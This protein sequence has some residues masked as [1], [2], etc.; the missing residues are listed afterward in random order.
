MMLENI[1][2]A[3]YF[4]E[5]DYPFIY[6]V[7]EEHEVDEDIKKII[8]EEKMSDELDEVLY[9]ISKEKGKVLYGIDGSHSELGFIHY[10]HSTS[11]HKYEWADIKHTTVTKIKLQSKKSNKSNVEETKQQNPE[12]AT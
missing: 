12:S 4:Y 10:C 6:R 3:E 1:S 8:P 5:N 11:I 9:S 2:M 7:C